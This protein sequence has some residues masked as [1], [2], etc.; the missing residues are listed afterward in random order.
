MPINIEDLT[1]AQARELCLMV[2][3]LGNT[4]SPTTPNDPVVNRGTEIVILQRGWIVVGKVFRQGY[5]VTIEKAS[6]IR[7]WG[8]TKGL[9]ELAENGPLDNTKLDF[10]GTIHCHI[11]TIVAEIECKETSW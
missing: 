2:G 3:N 4:P 1:I 10:A 9:G 7:R 6:V 8:T 11:L 5:N